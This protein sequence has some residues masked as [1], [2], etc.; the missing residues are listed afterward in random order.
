MFKFWKD[1]FMFGFMVFEGD[2][3]AGGGAAEGGGDPAA[4]SGDPGNGSPAKPE[5]LEDSFWD[6]DKGEIRL[7][8][9]IKSFNDTK[10]AFTG[11]EE[12]IRE[13][14]MADIQKNR[15]ESPEKYEIPKDIGIEPPEGYEIEFNSDDP[16]IDMWRKL[17]FQS[18]MSQDQFMEGIR[19][20]VGVMLGSRVDPAKE[21]EKL[22]EN[23]SDRITRLDNILNKHLEAKEVDFLADF[24]ST[25]DGVTIL[26][27]L[28][29][30]IGGDRVADGY[31]PPSNEILTKDELM[32]MM[33]DP[34]YTGRG[35]DRDEGFIKKVSDGFSKLNSSKRAG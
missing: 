11:K 2:P 28:I 21:L 4:A 31:T 19:S 22:G 5:G 32:E 14:L 10:A 3:A 16:M 24:V 15:P 13:R 25:A 17:A 12:S 34:R 6:S 18:N 23:G 26:E 8:S 9:L 7:D 29:N 20:Y 30:N 1:L 33:R 27:K 35:R